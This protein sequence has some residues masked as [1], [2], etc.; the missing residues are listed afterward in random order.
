MEIIN[1]LL[2]EVNRK[3]NLRLSFSFDGKF[4]RTE[5]VWAVGK[6]W[7]YNGKQYDVINYG[8][9]K[10]AEQF[11][12]KS[13]EGS[14]EN[15]AFKKDYSIQIHEMNRKIEEDKKIKHLECKEKWEP[16]F[17][18]AITPDNHPYLINKEILPYN[19]KVDNFKN[20]LIPFYNDNGFVGVQRINEN[21]EKLFS[22]GIEIQGA[23]CPLTPFEGKPLC[24]VSE[25][26]ATAATIQ[27]CFPDIPSICAA[28]AGNLSHAIKTIRRISPEIKICIAADCDKNKI[29][30]TKA[31]QACAIDKDI[32]YIVVKTESE[33]WTDFNDLA[34]FQGKDK[35]IEQLS[36]SENDFAYIKALGHNDDYYYYCS[37]NNQQII[38]LKQSNHN[39]SGFKHIMGLESFWFKHY[40]IKNEDGTFKGISWDKAEFDLKN[41]C[42][43][44]GIFDPRKIRGKGVWQDGKTFVINDGQ[45][46]HFKPDNSKYHYQ[47][48]SKASYDISKTPYDVFDMQIILRAIEDLPFK[49]RKENIFF[50]A[51][52]IQAQIFSVLP[53]RFHLWI[54]GSR[55]SGKSSILEHAHSIVSESL[56]VSDATA[57]GIRQELKSDA[58]ATIYDESEAS[59]K[60]IGP[61]IEMAR[62]MSTNGGA[63]SLRGTA[64]GKVIAQ[65][66]QTCF[67]FGSIQ[68]AQLNAADQS[69][70]FVTE[71]IPRRDN[72]YKEIKRV[73]N[74]T[75]QNKNRFFMTSF[76]A[77]EA[78]L[79]SIKI[80]REYFNGLGL[81][82]RQS[83]QLASMLACFH[84]YYSDISITPVDI[85]K[86]CDDYDLLHSEYIEETSEDEAEICL[87]EIFNIIIDTKDNRTIGSIIEN[88]RSSKRLPYSNENNLFEAYGMKYFT[89]NNL[90]FISSKNMNLIN[91]LKNY[92]NYCSIL[93][94]NNSIYVKVAN[95]KINSKQTKGIYINVV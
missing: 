64:T 86:Y 21:G 76:M 89:E 68:V 3:Y 61:V 93:K 29:G 15:K 66:T 81:E 43:Q 62:Q 63:R 82:A 4:H 67:L 9:W 90:L 17:K 56:F 7:H 11:T 70:I 50:A 83:D 52:L 8:S 72:N 69:R 13:W 73:L 44:E 2:D 84:V 55:G 41:K 87:A 30:E 88:I 77:I 16:K 46:V 47:K 79:E 92:E 51:W 14:E 36:I 45:E 71:V 5:H 80:A 34:V 27:E 22:S 18:T 6:S 57:A 42:Q 32:I 85:K 28:N 74:E 91:K 48:T 26:F 59:D 10:F 25:G 23:I 75:S 95:V 19:S 65:N 78:V 94:R 35:V 49:N 39:K 37:S 53:W 12:L 54:T 31:R 24:Y 60:K 58:M 40:G 1:Q 33:A 38:E 20:L